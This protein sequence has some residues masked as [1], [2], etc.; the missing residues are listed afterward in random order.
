MSIEQLQ[1][2]KSILY[3]FFDL[4][5]F[6]DTLIDFPKPIIAVLNGPAVGI[7][8]TTLALMD[9]VYASN[10]V[11]MQIHY[12]FSFPTFYAVFYKNVKIS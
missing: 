7:A 6:I 12:L 9:A 4:R 3:L 10:K 8:V 5:D 2:N 11:S 1:Q